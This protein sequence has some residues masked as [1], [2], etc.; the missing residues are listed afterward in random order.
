M[1]SYPLRPTLHSPWSRFPSS[2]PEILHTTKF[3]CTPSPAISS[4]P[5][6]LQTPG[7]LDLHAPNP[8]ATPAFSTSPT[9]PRAYPACPYARNY[10]ARWIRPTG[11]TPRNHEIYPAGSAQNKGAD[12]RS[13]HAHSQSKSSCTHS[14]PS[15]RQFPATS[16]TATPG[17]TPLSPAHASPQKSAQSNTPGTPLHIPQPPHATPHT[18]RSTNPC[19]EANVAH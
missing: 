17:C 4:D 7:Q 3:R 13:R 16:K 11:Y 8:A 15:H 6:P 18:V 2:A 1:S 12:S 19:P 9:V 5:D 14:A 10:L